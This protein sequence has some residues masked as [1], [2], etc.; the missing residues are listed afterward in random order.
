MCGIRLYFDISSTLRRRA[1]IK[2]LTVYTFLLF[3]LFGRYLDWGQGQ[4]RF[5]DDM[6]NCFGFILDP[7]LDPLPYAYL[8]GGASQTGG[9]GLQNF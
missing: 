5:G 3:P 9:R 4:Q 1:Y 6:G 8:S 2:T 7:P